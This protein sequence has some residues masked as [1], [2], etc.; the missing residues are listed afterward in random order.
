MILFSGSTASA[1]DLG[2]PILH[3]TVTNTLRAEGNDPLNRTFG[4]ANAND[5]IAEFTVTDDS[6]NGIDLQNLTYTAQFNLMDEGELGT[7]VLRSS[8]DSFSSDLAITTNTMIG[9]EDIPVNVD[10]SSLTGLSDIT[11]RFYFIGE[12]NEA[13]ERTR[14]ARTNRTVYLDPRAFVRNASDAPRSAVEYSKKKQSFVAEDCSKVGCLNRVVLRLHTH[15]AIRSWRLLSCL[16]A[17][18][19]LS[20]KHH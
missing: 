5:F 16:T 13:N 11:F 12:N 8:A 7:L 4:L 18:T 2:D 6:G 9:N 1:I 15:S 14:L 20:I 3:S 19:I 10:L 17:R